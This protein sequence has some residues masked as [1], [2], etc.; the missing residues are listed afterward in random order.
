T[1]FL[2]LAFLGLVRH[3]GS[4]DFSA[5][6]AA[7]ASLGGWERDVIFLLALLGFGTKAGLIP[8]H[9]WLPRAHP[10]APSHVSALMSGVMVKTAIYGLA[11]IVWEFAGPGPSWWGWLLIA[12]GAGSAVLGILYALMERDIKRV[13]AYSTVEQVGI[14]TV[15]LGV[16]TLATANGHPAVAALAITAA[17]LHL[18]NHSVFK[19]LLFLGAGAI[20]VGTG[21]R[22]LE[23]LGGLVRRM[24]W[25]A[26]LFLTGALAIASLPPLNG[27][28]GEWL[29]FQSLLGLGSAD[30]TASVATIVA[31]AV[32]AVALT[33]GLSVACFVR[34]FGIGFLAQPRS[35]AARDAH[36]VSRS[37]LAGMA[38]LAGCAIGLG[39]FPIAI[40]RLLRPVTTDLVGMTASPSLGNGDVLDATQLGG[41]YAPW[42]VVAGLIA[43]GIVPWL[44]ARLVGG[45]GRERVAPTWVCGGTLEPR[46]QYSATGFAKP[47]RLI[48]QALIRPVRTVVLGRP[49]SEHF[50]ASVRYEESVLP[51]YE[52]LFYER[53]VGLLVA[54]SHRVRALQSGSIRAY[55]AYLL[56]TLVVVLFVAR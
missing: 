50:V 5:F 31:L 21:T 8:L 41:A 29:L 47:I 28:A 13:L 46:M 30:G 49:V 42:L 1:G 9:I 52:R 40:V 15:G 35:D 48:F 45:R 24:P 53:G 4:F 18:L 37:M 11:R 25:T 55:L 26:G 39:L 20:Q 6:R 27:F 17:L 19:G 12:A 3:T 2:L 7:A 14:I 43:V 22:D 54:A 34:A 36:E 51:V 32:G 33:A 56:V 10:A 16:A 44:L 38:L 23:R